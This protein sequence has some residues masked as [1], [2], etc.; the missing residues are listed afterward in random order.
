MYALL[1]HEACI[2]RQVRT[3]DSTLIELLHLVLQNV[4]RQF[5][6]SCGKT[7]FKLRRN[8]S[9]KSAV[10]RTFSAG[11]TNSIICMKTAKRS[12]FAYICMESSFLASGP[13]IEQE[14]VHAQANLIPSRIASPLPI[15]RNPAIEKHETL[16]RADNFV[17]RCFESMFQV[18]IESASQP[19]RRGL[20]HPFEWGEG[21]IK[22]CK[23]LRMQSITICLENIAATCMPSSSPSSLLSA[24]SIQS[25][26]ET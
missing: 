8:T 4:F 21:K 3:A 5:L 10:F 12:D 13:P 25:L 6:Q 9:L 26:Q 16:Q 23:K 1:Q 19:S 2:D 11:I 24:K 14:F 22:I 17:T 18:R 7:I 20:H 15:A